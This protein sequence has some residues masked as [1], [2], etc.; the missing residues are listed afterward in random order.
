MIQDGLVLSL[1]ASDLNSYVSGSTVWNDVSGNNNS[2]TLTNG[3]TYNSAN[4]GSI[5]FDGT[6]DYINIPFSGNIYCIDFWIK[7]TTSISY[8]NT[9]SYILNFNNGQQSLAFG[10]CT[11]TITNELITVL[12]NSNPSIGIRSSYVSTTETI[13]GWTNIVTN[14]NGNHYVFTVN[15]N[16]KTT[17]YNQFTQEVINAINPVKLG[18]STGTGTTGAFDGNIANLKFYSQSLSSQEVLQNYNSLKSRFG[19]YT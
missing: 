13:S 5:V 7:P 1:D 8:I 12:T 2:G 9:G 10:S 17:T 14:W 6:N 4:G 19:I 3:P 11:A 15:G 18:L 16:T